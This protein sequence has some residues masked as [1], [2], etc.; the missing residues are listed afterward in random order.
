[1]NEFIAWGTQPKDDAIDGYKPE[2]S[3][4]IALVFGSEFKVAFSPD[5]FKVGTWGV[6]GAY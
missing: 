6:N 1:M 3:H 4:A 5:W 2:L